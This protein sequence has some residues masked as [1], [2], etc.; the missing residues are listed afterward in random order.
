[1]TAWRPGPA[2]SAFGVSGL[3]EFSAKSTPIFTPTLAGAVPG[4]HQNTG[5]LQAFDGTTLSKTI[6]F[7]GTTTVS[8]TF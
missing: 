2:P 7:N 5:I 1:M 4:R 8:F 6:Y 3:C